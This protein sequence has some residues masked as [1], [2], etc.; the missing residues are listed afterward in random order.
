MV[1]VAYGNGIIEMWDLEHGELLWQHAATS[2]QDHPGKAKNRAGLSPA[3]IQQRAIDRYAA[4]RREQF[5]DTNDAKRADTQL[6]RKKAKAARAAARANREE[7]RAYE[8]PQ[9]CVGRDGI[10]QV[11]PAWPA[12][13]SVVWARDMKRLAIGTQD[14]WIKIL[15]PLTGFVVCETDVEAEVM[16]VA[17]HPFE[18]Y[19]AAST[20]S[21]KISVFEIKYK[22]SGMT[23]MCS[24]S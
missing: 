20:A 8:D 14:A 17:F 19:L 1:A 11:L 12:V 24:L 4:S 9:R 3:E 5:Q 13:N 10:A 22:L 23:R 2:K 21:G 18:E 15:D 7:A 16:C 6:Q